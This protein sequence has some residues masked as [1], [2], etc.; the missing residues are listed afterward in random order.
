MA[1]FAIRNILKDDPD[2]KNYL[3]VFKGTDL[4][5][6]MAQKNMGISFTESIYEKLGKETFK[7]LIDDP[8]DTLE[9]KDARLYLKRILE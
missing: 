2:F 9:L 5:S 7:K 3:S 8:P 4:A 6:F 1:S